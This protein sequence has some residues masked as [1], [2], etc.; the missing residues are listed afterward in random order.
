MLEKSSTK[1]QLRTVHP[2]IFIGR[3]YHIV[4]ER[5]YTVNT[6]KNGLANNY[7]QDGSRFNMFQFRLTNHH[8]IPKDDIILLTLYFEN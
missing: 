6:D 4:S 3:D 8:F 5:R 1:K 2:I 7:K